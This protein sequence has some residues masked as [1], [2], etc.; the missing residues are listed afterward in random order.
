MHATGATYWLQSVGYSSAIIAC[1]GTLLCDLPYSAVLCCATLCHVQVASSKSELMQLLRNMAVGLMP[2][3]LRAADG[4]PPEAHDFLIR[5]GWH[6]GFWSAWA[7]L[8]PVR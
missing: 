1:A 7:L 4:P 3:L 6:W 5:G 8:N 2:E